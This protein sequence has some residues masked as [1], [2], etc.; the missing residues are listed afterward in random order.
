[1]GRL[2][3][4]RLPG[5]WIAQY[6]GAF[7]SSVVVFGVYYGNTFICVCCVLLH[8]KYECMYDISNVPC[9]MYHVSVR[10]ISCK[11]FKSSLQN[12]HIMESFSK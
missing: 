7:V 8:V 12:H 3:W 2:P 11:L 9:Q 10:D 4:R 1:M 6:L 5:Y